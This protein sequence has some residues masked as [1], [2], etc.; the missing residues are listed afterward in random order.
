M[1]PQGAPGLREGNGVPVRAGLG[2]VP[3]R[4]PQSSAGGHSPLNSPI[5][6]HFHSFQ[7]LAIIDDSSVNVPVMWTFSCIFRI[8][9][10]S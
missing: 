9:S 6:R 5:I 1:S 3:L 10:Q 8:I 7:V 4:L 2:L